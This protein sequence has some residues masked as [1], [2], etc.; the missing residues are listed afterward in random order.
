MLYGVYLP[1]EN[2]VY[3]DKADLFYEHLVS[4]MYEYDDI[5]LVVFMGD[6][7]SR[8]GARAD[9]I[10][11]LDDVPPRTNIDGEVNDHGK[12]LLQF[13]LQTKTCVLNGRIDPL[14]DNF[15]SISHRGRSVVDYIIV[16]HEHLYMVKSFRVSTVLDLM[17]EYGVMYDANS[18]LSDHSILCAKIIVAEEEILPES[19][20][21]HSTCQSIHKLCCDRSRV[22]HKSNISPYSQPP[23]RFRKAAIPDTFLTSDEILIKYNEVIT[24]LLKE[25]IE[26][27]EMDKI[28]DK[29]VNM[30]YQEMSNFLKEIRKSPSSGKKARFTKRPYWSEELSL[31]WKT[32]HEAEKYYL[33]LQNGHVELSLAR[34]K[35][36]EAQ[37]EFNKT[38]KKCKRSH[39]RK[40]VYDIEEANVNDPIE[41]WNSIARL[42]PRKAS[43][44]PWEIIDENGSLVTS[45]TMC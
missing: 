35:F 5:D 37:N 29:I 23:R 40:Q 24:D 2:S 44:I 45:K 34:T 32:Y 25:K 19:S 39:Q 22:E 14:S 10:E 31:L 9:Y 18:K 33:S 26:Q 7:N 13:M 30:Y 11:G 42:G 12:S 6:F 21:Q 43:G 41:F 36:I 17:N 15:T 16:P 38:L 28:Y 8:I 4:K 20:T 27:E 1:P 3:G